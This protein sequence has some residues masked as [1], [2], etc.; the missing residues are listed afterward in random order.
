MVCTF[1]TQI[2]NGASIEKFG[3]PSWWPTNGKGYVEEDVDEG[4]KKRY[5]EMQLIWLLSLG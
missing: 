1:P 2:R 5:K 3:Y 4:S